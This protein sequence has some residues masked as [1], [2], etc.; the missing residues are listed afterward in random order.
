MDGLAGSLRTSCN[1]YN[2]IQMT[3]N[4]IKEI[5]ANL[6]DISENIEG[7]TIF[8]TGGAGFFRLVAV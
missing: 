7:K 4:E 6:E 2:G 8:I 1:H 3:V 5:A